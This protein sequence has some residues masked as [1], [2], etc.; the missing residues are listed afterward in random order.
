[1]NDNGIVEPGEAAVVVA[2]PAPARLVVAGEPATT[3]IE[4]LLAALHR[5][6]ITSKVMRELVVRLAPPARPMVR[7]PLPAIVDATSYAKACRRI[8]AASTSGKI[9][10]GDA[11]TLLRNAKATWS[12]AVA[13]ARQRHRLM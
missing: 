13:A 2:P 9:T 6:E 3:V 1:M 7:L 8:M 11:A 5:G 4:G 10:P 12:A